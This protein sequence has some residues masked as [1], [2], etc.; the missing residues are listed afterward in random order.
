MSSEMKVIED[1]LKC[2]FGRLVPAYLNKPSPLS[3]IQ[4]HGYDS[5]GY[6]TAKRRW[7]RDWH[8]EIFSNRIGSHGIL[9][10]KLEL[11]RER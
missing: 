8:W 7:F 11:G 2:T 1:V 6:R 3:Y 10:T 5:N 9:C 4:E